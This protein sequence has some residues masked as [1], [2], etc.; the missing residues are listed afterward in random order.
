MEIRT[1]G[2]FSPGSPP[3]PD[4]LESGLRRLEQLDLRLRLGRTARGG[5]GLHAAPPE[6]RAQDFHDLLRD[7]EVDA[8]LCARGGSGTMGILPHI[9]YA[10]AEAAGKAV[11][12]LSDV[13]ALHLALFARCRLGGVAG[14]VLVQFGPEMPA[15]TVE[16]WRRLLHGP[17]ARTPL[18][19]P[20]GA[21]L[22]PLPGT[23]PR[24]VEGTLLPCNLSLLTSLLGTGY[25]PS[26]E[27]A[28][29]VLEEVHET[30][31]SLDRM[32]SALRLSGVDRGWAGLVLGQFT[33]CRP[34]NPGVTEAEGVAVMHDWAR[35]LGIPVLTGFP[36]GHEADC[37]SLP[38]GTRAR[39]ETAPPGLTLTEPP[40][41]QR[42][43]AVLA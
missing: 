11:L 13:T 34:H 40:P 39:L 1:L 25:L 24:S 2:V 43:S 38:F 26:L 4:R 30:P 36:F 17:H 15:Y 27:N 41:T 18:A 42:A 6:V 32:A 8:I 22:A 29:V 35:S 12:G 33:E 3:R 21:Q 16:S 23:P 10:L 14:P 5:E 9:D 19:L 7:P 31:Q 37:C 20:P 28:I